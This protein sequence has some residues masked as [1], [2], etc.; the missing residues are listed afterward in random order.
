MSIPESHHQKIKMSATR[1]VNPKFR[2]N[3][4]EDSAVAESLLAAVVAISKQNTWFPASV[5][6]LAAASV[7]LQAV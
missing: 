5:S 4:A 3:V 1:V 7:R 6:N 2:N